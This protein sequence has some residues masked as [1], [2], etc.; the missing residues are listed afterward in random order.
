MSKSKSKEL[1]DIL[2]KSGVQKS[3]IYELRNKYHTFDV[4]TRA[5]RQTYLGFCSKLLTDMSANGATAEELEKAIMFSLVVLDSEK[6]KLSIIKAKDDMDIQMLYE[7]YK[8][9]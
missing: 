3:T 5:I 6:Y 4:P 8:G 2:D 9:A 1:K 7:K